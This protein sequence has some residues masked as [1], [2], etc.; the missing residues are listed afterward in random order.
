MA[1]SEYQLTLPARSET[2]DDPAIA[3]VLGKVKDRLGRIPNLYARMANMPGLYETYRTG[4]EAFR[5]DS[6]FSPGRA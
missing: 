4:Y 3:A 2:D 6:G 5:Q 1:Q